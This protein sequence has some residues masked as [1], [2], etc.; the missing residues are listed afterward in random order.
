MKIAQMQIV[1]REKE[2]VNEKNGRP[3]ATTNGNKEN[4]TKGTENYSNNN[5][6]S[7]VSSA[8]SWSSVCGQNIV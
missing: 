4:N 3:E 7:D 6:G 2:K 5:V 1:Q 8:S